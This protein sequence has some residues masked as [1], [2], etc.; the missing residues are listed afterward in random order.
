MGTTILSNEKGHFGPSDR[1]VQTGQSGPPSKLVPNIPVGPNRN[2]PVHLMYQPKF[3][4]FW[5][6]WKEP[7]DLERQIGRKDK[8]SQ[9]LQSVTEQIAPTDWQ[10]PGVLCW[11]LICGLLPG[12]HTVLGYKIE[13]KEEDLSLM[14]T[15]MMSE[16]Y[17]ASKI[18]S[19]QF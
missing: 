17:L 9:R 7:I 16:C 15:K 18:H 5:V 19:M 6:E 8:N 13:I 3:P 4:E 10:V 12:F 14:S 11:C 1:N 2:G